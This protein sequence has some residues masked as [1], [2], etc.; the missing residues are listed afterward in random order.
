M[1]DTAQPSDFEYLGH[2]AGHNNWVT[3]LQTSC[4]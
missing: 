3:C 2:L 1:A 4:V